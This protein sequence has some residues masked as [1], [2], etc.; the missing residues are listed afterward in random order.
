MNYEKWVR[1]SYRDH[2]LQIVPVKIW[3]SAH[4]SIGRNLPFC[5]INLTLVLSGAGSPSF[6]SCIADIESSLIVSTVIVSSSIDDF[7]CNDVGSSA[8]NVAKP[9]SSGARKVKKN[10]VKIKHAKYKNIWCPWLWLHTQLIRSNS[11]KM[12]LIKSLVSRIFCTS[13][14]SLVALPL[15]SVK[16]FCSYWQL[17]SSTWSQSRIGVNLSV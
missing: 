4:F 14:A 13:C 10:T 8:S 15:A 11:P 17:S 5:P 16:W 12:S 2:K 7:V 1:V 6:V 3:F 9:V